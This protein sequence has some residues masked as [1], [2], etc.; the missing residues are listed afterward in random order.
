MQVDEKKVLNR[1]KRAEGQLRGVQKMVVTDKECL[2]V[3]TQ[4]TAVRSSIDRLIG[5]IVAENLKNCLE[6]PVANPQ[7]QSEK[8][9][10]A[11]QMI[12]RK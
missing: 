4:L 3:I 9:E 8:I 2:E 10:Q 11:I 5:M 1:L 7:E 12:M 6:D